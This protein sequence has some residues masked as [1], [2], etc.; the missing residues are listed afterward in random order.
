MIKNYTQRKKEKE[1]RE[2]EREK[3]DRP[4]SR[5]TIKNFSAVI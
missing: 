1:G 3:N 5:M 4:I 2:S